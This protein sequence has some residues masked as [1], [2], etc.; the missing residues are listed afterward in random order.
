MKHKLFNS[1]VDSSKCHK[2]NQIL[3]LQV[4]AE[5][6]VTCLHTKNKPFYYFNF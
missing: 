2:Q 4:T 5:K 3:A 6:I 1:I